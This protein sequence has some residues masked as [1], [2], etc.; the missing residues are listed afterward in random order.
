V[1]QTEWELEMTRSKARGKCVKVGKGRLS[2]RV[3]M[4]GIQ[5]R[6]KTGSWGS[7]VRLTRPLQ[8]AFEDGNS[9]RV[10]VQMEQRL[11]GN[12]GGHVQSSVV[13]SVDNANWIRKGEIGRQEECTF[14]QRQRM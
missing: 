2:L 4:G 14:A 9:G 8:L 10:C 3:R 11:E 7:D 6:W 1:Y 13:G 12:E 5:V